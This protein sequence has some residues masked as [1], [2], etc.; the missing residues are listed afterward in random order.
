[1]DVL[2]GLID[3]EG[4]QIIVLTHKGNW[5]D[6]VCD[7]CRSI[8]GYRYDITG[9]D[10]KG[11]NIIERNWAPIENRIKEVNAILGNVSSPAERIQQAD[12]ELRLIACQLA[13]K[14]A[15]EKLDRTTSVHNMSATDVRNILTSAGAPV[16]DI[17]DLYAVQSAADDAHHTPAKYQPNV[18][19]VRTGINVINRVKTW[20]G[21]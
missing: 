15:K 17:D 3:E 12:E 11:P 19:R 4:K 1:M 14:V 16:K 9:Y 8:N 20:L 2:R 10:K 13:Q 18:Q 7:G 21:A 5:A 6:R